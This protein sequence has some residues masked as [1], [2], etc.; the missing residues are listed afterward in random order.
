MGTSVDLPLSLKLVRAQIGVPRKAPFHYFQQATQPD[1]AL[2]HVVLQ[3]KAFPP[4][5]LF[6]CKS[7]LQ[8]AHWPTG[9]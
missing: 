3:L 2:Q 4:L 1:P 9:S 6:V 5:L 8:Q 7:Q